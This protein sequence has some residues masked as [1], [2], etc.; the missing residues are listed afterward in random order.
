MLVTG[1][2][3]SLTVF[4]QGTGSVVPDRDSSAKLRSE[5]VKLLSESGSFGDV[6]FQTSIGSVKLNGCQLKIAWVSKSR[7]EYW[8]EPSFLEDTSIAATSDQTKVFQTNTTI[9]LD[10][11]RIDLARIS[12]VDGHSPRTSFILIPATFDNF[13]TVT[14]RRVLGEPKT[15]RRELLRLVVKQN[16][17]D[18]V[19]SRLADLAQQ[20]QEKD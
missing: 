16:S 3:L 7:L 13:I 14:E 4:G 20:C 18:Q 15:E 19:A 9:S 12:K 10:L 11:A 1:L 8:R 5:F 6:N 2:L 17:A